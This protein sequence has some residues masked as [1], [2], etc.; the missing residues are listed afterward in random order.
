MPY[1]SRVDLHVHTLY[2]GTSDDWILRVMKS[3]ECYT[4]P[5]QVYDRAQKA[6]MDFVTISD[7]DEISGALE[8]AHLP[9]AFVSEE[10]TAFF[11][12]DQCKIHVL[13][14]GINEA[15]HRDV[16]KLRHN[17]YELV[18]YLN[19]Q[20]LVHAIAHPFF[21]MSRCHSIEHVE[22]MLLLFKIVEAKNGGK[23]TYPDD[24]LLRIIA[25]LTPERI[26]LL[27][28][29]HRLEPIGDMPG[30]KSVIGGSD[31]HAGIYIGRPHTACPQV[32]TVAELLTALREG[33]SEV[34]GQ[35]G[36]P[37]VIAHSIYSVGY[38]YFRIEKHRNASGAAWNILDHVLMQQAPPSKLRIFA[39]LTFS[40][41]KSKIRPKK[42]SAFAPLLSE[43]GSILRTDPQW[44]QKLY[45]AIPSDPIEGEK[46][47]QAL[48]D[49]V[50]RLL[51]SE[52]AGIEKM[53]FSELPGRLQRLGAL[54]LFIAP[55]IVG[56]HT[57]SRDRELMKRTRQSFLGA[58]PKDDRER[59]AWFIDGWSRLSRARQRKIHRAARLAGNVTLVTTGEPPEHEHIDHAHFS[60]LATMTPFPESKMQIDVPPLLDIVKFIANESFTRIEL[61]TPGPLG[62]LGLGIAR[63]MNLPI[64][65]VKTNMLRRWS[66]AHGL[67]G[68][69][70]KLLTKYLVWFGQE[71]SRHHS[72]K[73]LEAVEEIPIQGFLAEAEKM[74]RLAASWSAED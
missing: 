45:R 31:D 34:I 61:F 64:D 44:R 1:R 65:P 20:N 47:A 21:R 26:S 9:N 27:A 32:N 6:G 69:T 11:P 8:I 71:T 62:L 18:K 54:L 50:H 15:Q 5:M 51:Q 48:Q 28:E 30:K 60:T 35:G 57:E 72:S 14:F 53:N 40:A 42:K 13:V 25:S 49:L 70:G 19:E 36:A 39:S 16:Q 66:Y 73:P 52:L 46:Y 10:V 12:E 23:Q 2:S 55:Y 3:R 67:A 22:K 41:A 17:V 43:A 58:S 37:E 68:Q 38:K 29:K 24:L 74:T 63:L 59:T 56:Y 7:H 33:N 4:T